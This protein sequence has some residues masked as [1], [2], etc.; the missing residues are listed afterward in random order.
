MRYIY[1][2]SSIAKGGR[3]RGLAGIFERKEDAIKAV[4][5]SGPHDIWEYGGY[6]ACIE[7]YRLNSAAGHPA[8]VADSEVEAPLWFEWHCDEPFEKTQSGR[9]V[10]LREPPEWARQIYGWV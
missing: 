4:L 10:P 7:K 5:E 1:V 9:Y 6:L 8:I 2:I 3:S